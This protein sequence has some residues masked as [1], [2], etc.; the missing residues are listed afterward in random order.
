MNSHTHTRYRRP[1]V[2]DGKH[3][4]HTGAYTSQ[5]ITGWRTKYTIE[6]FGGEKEGREPASPRELAGSGEPGAHFRF[7]SSGSKGTKR[8][9]AYTATAHCAGWRTRYTLQPFLFGRIGSKGRSAYA[10]TAH[11]GV[12]ENKEQTMQCPHCH[13]SSRG[14]ANHVYTLAFFIWNYRK[15]EMQCPYC[16]RS[17]RG[18]A[19]R[20]HT[21]AFF[22]LEV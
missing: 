22:C 15:Q 11:C 12:W 17:L 4:S 18:V 14:V 20:A 5:D 21:P 9:S 13:G 16:L 3:S 19:D 1:R 2:W 8:R 10:A 6:P 7:F